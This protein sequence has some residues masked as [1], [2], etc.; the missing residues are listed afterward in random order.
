MKQGVV[1]AFLLL[2]SSYAWSQDVHWSQ[3]DYNPVF[4]SPSNVGQFN[5]D[6][7]IHGNYR[8]QWRSVTVPFQTFSV[9]G[10]AKNVFKNLN[11]GAFIMADVVG[12]GKMTTVEFQPSA[13]Y[14]LKLTADS[15]HLLRPGI[16]M[17]IN[18]RGLN[19]DA[20]YYDEQWNGQ[21]FDQNI[22]HNESFVQTKRT[23]FTLGFGL[24][25]E[26]QEGKRKRFQAGI[27]VFNL[28]RPDQGFFGEK[29]KREIRTNIFARAEFKIGFDW[30]LLPSIQFNTQGKY[31]EL[32][33]GTQ[34]R[35]ILKD[36]LGEYRAILAGIYTR[37]QDALFLTAGMEYQNWWAGISYDIN[38]SKLT[39]ASRARGGFEVSVRYIIHHFKPKRISHRI[40]P[41]YI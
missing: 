3:F 34:A 18:F 40:C 2:W 36:R 14:T 13:S 10:E 8:D 20:F 28:N 12:D 6:Y 33:L 9:S 24:G 19:P 22:A 17:G 4:Q 11:V 37:S 5:G 15:V 38:Y 29:I 31:L 27:G 41:D 7:R 26:Y 35:Y 1:I 39:P 32:V 23:N 16:Q 21:Q 30:D 25:Y